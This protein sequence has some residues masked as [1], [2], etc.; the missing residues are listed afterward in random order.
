MVGRPPNPPCPDRLTRDHRKERQEER[1]GRS[2]NLSRHCRD[3][4]RLRGRRPRRDPDL[5]GA[6]PIRSRRRP[7][8]PR[9]SRPRSPPAAR[10]SGARPSPSSS[11]SRSTRPPPPRR[12]LRSPAGGSPTSPPGQGLVLMKEAL[13]VISG[14]RCRG[15]PRRGPRLTSQALNIHAGHD[16]VMAVADAGWGILFARNVQEVA[17]LTAIARRAE[18]SDP[19]PR[20]PGRLPDDAHPRERP[21][22]RGRAAPRFV[23]DPRLRSPTCSSRPRRS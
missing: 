13:Y 7:L 18:A 1:A 4:R 22:A 16:D 2:S 23:G 5:R 3:R 20:R 15:V 19:V 17:D 10:T 8:W 14:K 6:A 21:T 11:P 12:A 9:S